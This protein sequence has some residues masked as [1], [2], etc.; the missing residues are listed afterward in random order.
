MNLSTIIQ[1]KAQTKMGLKASFDELI[2]MQYEAGFRNLNFTFCAIEEELK[3]DN[4]EKCI[5]NRI[6]LAKQKGIVFS[7]AHAPFH[8]KLIL[9]DYKED[10]N[11]EVNEL[12]KKSIILASK[13]N[14]KWITMHLGAYLDKN[15][16]YDIE[17]SIKYNIEFLKP[18]VEVAKKYNVGIAMET[19]TGIHYTAPSIEELI[20]ITDIINNNEG[21]EVVGVCYDC[22]HVRAGNGNQVESI[23][24][25]G[26]RLKSTHIHDNTGVDEH[27][28]PM[29]GDINFRELMKA[30]KQ[31]DYKGDLSLEVK[32]AANIIDD[33]GVETYK[34]ALEILKKIEKYTEL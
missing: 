21:Q 18:F 12:I 17:N 33:F 29:Y 34:Y 24:R 19:M 5:D 26:H 30:L 9:N 10:D 4:W 11:V 16:N 13:A 6:E 22:G 15:G 23:K 8:S 31:I 32:Y 1:M 7:S 3:Q 28:L 25:L 20:K 2:E 27:L 14:I